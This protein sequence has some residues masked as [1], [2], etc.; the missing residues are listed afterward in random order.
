MPDKTLPLGVS[1]VDASEVQLMKVRVESYSTKEQAEAIIE[2]NKRFYQGELRTIAPDAFEIWKPLAKMQV[3][4]LDAAKRGDLIRFLIKGPAETEFITAVIAEKTPNSLLRSKVYSMPSKTFHGVEYSDEL[5]V[6][7]N[8]VV[9]HEP[10]SANVLKDMEPFLTGTQPEAV[11]INAEDAQVRAAT[12]KLPPLTPQAGKRYWTRNGLVVNVWT[13]QTYGTTACAYCKRQL[14]GSNIQTEQCPANQG[15][16]HT[17]Q[18]QQ[19][20]VWI[21]GSQ[22]G[23]SLE[24]NPDG[25]HA[26]GIKDFDI[27]KDPKANEVLA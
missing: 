8:K 12:Q 27:V 5:T 14:L 26:G 7:I 18:N 6:S 9:T 13:F 4:Q 22:D 24:W 19:C 23:G 16:Y 21:G 11:P 20:S 15:Q 2:A 1:I 25:S 3:A 17:W 10:T